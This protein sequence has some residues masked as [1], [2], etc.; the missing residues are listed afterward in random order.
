[1]TAIYAIFRHA[2]FSPEARTAFTA[3]P[4]K[5]LLN[6][7]S[8]DGFAIALVEIAAGNQQESQAN[9]R[10]NFVCLLQGKDIIN[11]DLGDGDNE[12]SQRPTA[13]PTGTA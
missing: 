11:E 1:M 8:P 3:P 5:F 6:Q 2:F 7:E 13:A 10:D 4:V 9:E 12:Q